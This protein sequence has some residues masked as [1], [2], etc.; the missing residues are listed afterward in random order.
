MSSPKCPSCG[1][2]L[3]KVERSPSSP[4]NQEQFDAAKAGDFFCDTCPSNERGN[5]RFRYYWKRELPC[6][7]PEFYANVDVNRLVDTGR[8]QA[9][10]RIECACCKK[11][12]R[13]IGLPAGLDFNGAATNPDATEARLA[14]APEGE[15]VSMLEGAPLGFSIRRVTK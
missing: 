12:F 11:R 5:A 15:V 13:F 9:D 4:L 3:Q 2:P 1:K 8:Y 7:H 14:I 10:V 6:D